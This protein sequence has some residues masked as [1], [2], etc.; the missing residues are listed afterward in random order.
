MLLNEA[1]I[2]ENDDEYTFESALEAVEDNDS[3]KRLF[4]Q[5][6]V[7]AIEDLQ[8]NDMFKRKDAFHWFESPKESWLPHGIS[9]GDV[10]TALDINDIRRSKISDKIEEAYDLFYRTK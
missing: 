9:Y 5:V 8:S 6:L 10:L 7:T 1:P 4:R 2:D 3:Y